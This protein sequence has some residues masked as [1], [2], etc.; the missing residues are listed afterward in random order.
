MLEPKLIRI[1]IL[2]FDSQYSHMLA[3]QC[4]GQL[5]AATYARAVESKC[6]KGI[7]A[8][9][10]RNLD[11]GYSSSNRGGGESNSNPPA[12]THSAEAP[13]S[14]TRQGESSTFRNMKGATG[15]SAFFLAFS[16]RF[17]GLRFDA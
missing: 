14:M 5:Q 16:V 12:P 6:L 2:R 15:G 9:H 1:V 13:T 3:T 4:Q 8:L 11:H 7:P 10:A 17:Q